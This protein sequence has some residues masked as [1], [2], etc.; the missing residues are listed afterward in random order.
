MTR[1]YAETQNPKSFKNP[2][3]AIEWLNKYTDYNQKDTYQNTADCRKTQDQYVY[4]IK[5]CT[6][7]TIY[8]D[9]DNLN[10]IILSHIIILYLVRL[11]NMCCDFISYF[12]PVKIEIYKGLFS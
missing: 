6:Y 10:V 3:Y 4:D 1:V 12:S 11:E 7:P 9:T 2:A 5:D 8:K